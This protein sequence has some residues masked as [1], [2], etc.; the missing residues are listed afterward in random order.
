M[1][2]LPTLKSLALAFA[3]L[4]VS[5]LS[6]APAQAEELETALFAGGCFWCVEADFDKVEGVK[7]TISGFAGGTVENPTYR[8]VVSGGTG[9]REVV[10]VTFDPTIVTYETLLEVFWH[11]VDPT[12]GGGQFCDRG[13]AY[14]TAIYALDE[15]Q[16]LAAEASKATIEA[17]LEDP[18]VTPVERVDAFYPAEEYHQNYYQ[19]QER[20]LARFGYTTKANA[21]KRYRQ[22]CGRDAQVKTVWGDEAFKGIK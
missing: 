6:P 12:D 4:T 8:E 17:R 20:I 16:R 1:R 22:A 15:T 21:Y 2:T 11:S 13:F 9:H 18:V 5:P 14:T 3:I 10:K 7:E 19:S